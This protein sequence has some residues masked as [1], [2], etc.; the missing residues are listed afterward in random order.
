MSILTALLHDK[1]IIGY[2]RALINWSIAVIEN[3]DNEILIDVC[4]VKPRQLGDL[5]LDVCK[6]AKTAGLYVPVDFK[7]EH[8]LI[9]GQPDELGVSWTQ[10][11]VKSQK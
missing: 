2:E 5:W 6:A 10:L 11:L 3:S 4:P 8:M 9:D 1:G 7:V